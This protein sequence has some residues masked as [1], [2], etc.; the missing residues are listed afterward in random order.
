LTWFLTLLVCAVWT[1]DEGVVLMRRRFPN[2]MERCER[3]PLRQWLS[4]VLDWFAT[5]TGVM[6]GRRA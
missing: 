4:R 5:A 6:S 1:R 3:H 2:A